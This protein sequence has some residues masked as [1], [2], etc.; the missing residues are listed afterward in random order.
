MSGLSVYFGLFILGG[1]LAT[2]QPNTAKAGLLIIGFGLLLAVV[3]S[4]V[5]ASRVNANASIN[6]QRRE[7]IG[8]DPEA[9]DALN[10]I[11]GGR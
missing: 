10:R 9:R 2:D 5:R 1:A 8:Y 3:A 11:A 7:R 4:V 6:L